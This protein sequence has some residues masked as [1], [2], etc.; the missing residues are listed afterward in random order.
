MMNWMHYPAADGRTAIVVYRCRIDAAE[1]CELPIEYSADNRAQLYLDGALVS[2]GPERGMPARWYFQRLTLKLSSGRHVLCA[3]G[4]Q[5]KYDDTAWG[6]LSVR[7][8][9]AVG[10][11]LE[12]LPWECKVEEM[13]YMRPW[14]D[15]GAYPRVRINSATYPAGILA[16]D[17]DGWEPAEPFEDTRALFPPELPPMRR[18]PI[19]PKALRPGLWRFDDYVCAYPVY[20]FCGKGTARV[21]WSECPYDDDFY[22][23]I[24]LKGHKGR[25]DGS[26]FKGC[27]EEFTV[28][29]RL[30]WPGFYWRAGRYVEVE[31]TGDVTV[32]MEF[33]RTGYPL[34]ECHTDDPLKRAA[35]ETLR[36][37]C[38]ETFM[39]CPF[40]EQ[41]QY[42]GDS[43]LEA[44]CIYTLGDDHRLPA[45]ALRIFACGQMPDGGMVSHAPTRD[46]QRIPS[47]MMI[48]FLMLQDYWRIHGNDELVQELRPVADRQVLFFADHCVDGFFMPQEDAWNFVDWHPDWHNG[49]PNGSGPCS[50]LN[51]LYAMALRAYGEIYGVTPCIAAAE[52][53]LDRIDQR[54]LV[55]ESGLYLSFT[56]CP[57]YCEHAQVLALLCGRGDTER[58]KAGLRTVGMTPCSI[59]F[60]Y[61]Y[62][63]ACRKAGL[64]ELFQRRME[65]YRALLDD[66]LKTLPEEFDNPRSDCHAWSSHVMLFE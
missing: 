35:Y 7:H 21:R 15:W 13:E 2:E 33:F 38:F 66:G 52:R 4:L 48:W 58:L 46:Y 26:F 27:W 28:D 41:M 36:N 3:R 1:A 23:R 49:V 32:E 6:Q 37:C 40:Y 54:F 8:G 11:G 39:D 56:D 20:H 60:S 12:K 53:L 50:M 62:F 34:P 9:F 18:E 42:I 64:E 22:D 57:D 29:G 51:F 63:L 65:R 61:Y 45:K 30:D 5:F 44:L 55:P 47:F 25:R 43:R 10:G 16:G 59:Y 14:P 24:W 19:S 17:G 31:T